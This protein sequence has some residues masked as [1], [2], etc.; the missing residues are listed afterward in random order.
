MIDKKIIS[1]NFSKSM[2]S[3]N[4]LALVQKIVAKKIAHLCLPFIKKNAKILDLGSGTSFIAKNLYQKKEFLKNNAKIY[5]IDIAKEM[6]KSWKKRP[7][8]I[9]P[10]CCDIDQLSFGAESF[11]ILISSFSLQWLE[12]F[13]KTFAEFYRIL[14]PKGI[15]IFA[16]PNHDSLSEL[17]NASVESKCNFNFIQLPDDK[18]ITLILERLNFNQERIFGEILK[19][20]FHSAADALYDIKA[21][22]ANYSLDYSGAGKSISKQKLKDF[23]DFCIK[24]YK[25]PIKKSKLERIFCLSKILLLK[26]LHKVGF[27]KPKLE[28]FKSQQKQNKNIT[29][30]WDVSYFIFSKS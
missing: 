9:F 20:E 13:E 30:S 23:N 26:L 21:I 2:Q 25:T 17:R 24:N 15:F 10:I 14:K 22:G 16:V 8:N 7:K 3:Y 6:L 18:K 12:N 19:S 28:N 4:K 11:D 1:K 29:I 27:T 5:E